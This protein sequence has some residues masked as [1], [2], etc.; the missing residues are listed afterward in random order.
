MLIFLVF[1]V[2]FF[3]IAI[4]CFIPLIIF[5]F[6]KNKHQLIVKKE[7]TIPIV[8][9]E[10]YKQE[11]KEYQATHEPVK[12]VENDFCFMIIDDYSN[13]LYIKVVDKEKGV[14]FNIVGNKYNIAT[15]WTIFQ[16][17]FN[18]DITYNGILFWIQDYRRRSRGR[19]KINK[20]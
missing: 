7:E 16:M 12:R 3:I 1:T 8:P 18:S 5:V 20:F 14:G 11:I 9:S 17:Y 15:I 13:G 19:I 10:Y 2:I 4:L 6:L